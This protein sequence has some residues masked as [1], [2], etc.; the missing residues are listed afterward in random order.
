MDSKS[1]SKERYEK[2][3]NHVE[4]INKEINHGT[5]YIFILGGISQKRADVEKLF[6]ALPILGAGAQ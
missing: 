5:M 3:V 6:N 4:N 2:F 1:F